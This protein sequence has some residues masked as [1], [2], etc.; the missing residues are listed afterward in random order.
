MVLQPTSLHKN[1]AS[2]A[3]TAVR[4]NAPTVV[5]YQNEEGDGYRE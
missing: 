2:V 5:D 1:C 3:A 4:S